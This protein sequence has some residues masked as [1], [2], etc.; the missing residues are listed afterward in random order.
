MSEASFKAIG[1]HWHIQFSPDNES[2][3]QTIKDRIELFEQN[4]SRFRGD[5]FVGQIAQQEGSYKL[6]DD[7][8]KMLGL[9]RKLYAISNGKVTPLIGSVL[10]DA[11]YD[12]DYSLTPKEIIHKAEIWDDVMEYN[13]PFLTTKKPLQLDFGG[14]GKGYIVDI[15]ADMLRDHNIIDFTINAGGDIA[16]STI[17]QEVFRVGLEDP[18]NNTKIVGIADLVNKSIA[19]SSGNRRTWANHHHIIDP[20]STESPRHI[21]ALWVVADTTL[22]ADGLATALFFVEPDVLLQHFS[23]EYVIVYSDRS[24][25]KSEGFVGEVY[26]K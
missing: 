4:Y 9:Y 11:G 7:A 15:V 17:K 26:G 20:D 14:L 13:P 3:I 24:V 2:L 18:E 8:E 10:V 21:A 12:K 5:S 23:F 22:F 19:G 25:K 1:T 16:Y 6:P